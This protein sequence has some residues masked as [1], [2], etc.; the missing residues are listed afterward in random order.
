MRK[1]IAAATLALAAL[2]AAAG[3][4]GQP[5]GNAHPVVGTILFERP[6]GYF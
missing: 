6:D 4:F 2:P 1:F 5:D 3:T